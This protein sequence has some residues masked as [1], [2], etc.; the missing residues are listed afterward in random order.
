MPNNKGI[1]DKILDFVADHFSIV[2]VVFFSALSAFLTWLIFSDGVDTTVRK[3]S[4]PT[5]ISITPTKRID[6]LEELVKE[7][8]AE[9]DELRWEVKRLDK[10]FNVA[11]TK[12]LIQ[13]ITNIE[14]EAL[15]GV[16]E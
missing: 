10:T 1:L 11:V 7:C 13:E 2:A 12:G 16:Y 8:I 9:T 5:G 3:I 15:E 6:R 4:E 14:I